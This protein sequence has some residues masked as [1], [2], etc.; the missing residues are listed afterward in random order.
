M[1]SLEILSNPMSA[2]SH[3]TLE[4]FLARVVPLRLQAQTLQHARL[5]TTTLEC[6]S[7]LAF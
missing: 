6:R 3:K 4:R 2:V 7:R 1:E 5:R